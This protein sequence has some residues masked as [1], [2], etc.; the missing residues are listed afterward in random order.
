[1][2][3]FLFCDLG[4]SL[5]CVR[6]VNQINQKEL[7]INKIYNLKFYLSVISTIIFFISIVFIK[8]TPVEK[9]TLYLIGLSILFTGISVDYMFNALSNMKYV[10]I[11]VAIKNMTFFIL[12]LLFI[13]NSSNVYLVSIFYTISLLCVVI[14]LHFKFNR[15]YF[16]LKIHKPNLKDFNTFRSSLPLA[17]SLFMVQINNNF[18]IV[19]LSFMKTNEEVGYYSASYK[20]I[21]FLITV[22]CIYFNA[23]YP[24]IAELH[25]KGKVELT[26]YITGF[27]TIGI[28][29]VMPIVFGGIAL[30]NKI[31]ILFFG[32][33]YY[34][35]QIL[36]LLL[37]PLILVRM[38]TSTYG[39]VLIMG[40][41]SKAFSKGVIIGAVINILLNVILVPNYGARGSAIATLLC[42]SIQGIY[43]FYHFKKYCSS[44]F[45]KKSIIP[46]VSSCIMY[47]VLMLN[48]EM[49]LYLSIVVGIVI[50]L[51]VF[52]LIYSIVY[53]YERISF[54]EFLKSKINI[55]KYTKRK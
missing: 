43:L 46:T 12:C 38:L 10:G 45:L 20:I 19:Y 35:S 6:E 31:I 28:I 15:I 42:E 44:K 30:G 23:S 8:K 49:N 34:E 2:Y 51:A 4:L 18:D 41:G 16:K 5:Y 3:F 33:E 55:E 29:F 24:I 37:I 47:M 25:K 36:F 11:S 32:N 50:Y 13:R 54:F 52:I 39:A 21:N 26:N 1:M 53:P 40:N 9:S 22:L 14:F 48:T 27:Y 17:I 7:I